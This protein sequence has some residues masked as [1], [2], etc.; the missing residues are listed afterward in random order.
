MFIVQVATNGEVPKNGAF[1]LWCQIN[2][3]LSIYVSD[4][5]VHYNDLDTERVFLNK[6]LTES[7]N[8]NNYFDGFLFLNEI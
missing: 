4:H 8:W 6:N 3:H 2:F 5:P 7:Y 1:A